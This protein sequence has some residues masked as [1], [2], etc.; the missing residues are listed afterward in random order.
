[1][2]CACKNAKKTEALIVN[3]NDKEIQKKGVKRILSW[4]WDSF[5]SLLR[6]IM[7]IFLIFLMVPIVISILICNLI[8]KGEMYFQIPDWFMKKKDNLERELN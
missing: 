8:F 2:G 3:A 7:V 5:A 1:M 4:L 6:Y